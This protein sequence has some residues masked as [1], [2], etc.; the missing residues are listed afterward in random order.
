[1]GSVRPGSVDVREDEV[2]SAGRHAESEPTVPD[3]GGQV[4]RL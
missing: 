3:R 4:T 2:D 1:M